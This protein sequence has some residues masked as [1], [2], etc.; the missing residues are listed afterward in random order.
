MFWKYAA[1]KRI[2][3]G[4]VTRQLSLPWQTFCAPLVAGSSLYQHPTTKLIG[5][6]TTELLQFFTEYV[7]LPCD[8]DLWPLDLGVMLSDATRVFNTCAKF[9][10]YRVSHK[11]DPY[12]VLPKNFITNGTFSTFSMHTPVF[13]K[14]T[15][16]D[17]FWCLISKYTEYDNIFIEFAIKIF[18]RMHIKG[19]FLTNL[20]S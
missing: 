19:S 7:A 13:N 16:S 15:H 9:E 10:I 20:W 8:L 14:D 2:F 1:I 6:P 12:A 5:P 17:H 4:P 11:N 18:N 3:R